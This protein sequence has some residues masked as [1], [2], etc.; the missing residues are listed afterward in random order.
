M[1]DFKKEIQK[2]K[3]IL[4]VE[5]VENSINSDEIKDMM[6]ILKQLSNQKQDTN[7]R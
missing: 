6:D 4:E 3:P 5:D 1:L 2:Y 7:N